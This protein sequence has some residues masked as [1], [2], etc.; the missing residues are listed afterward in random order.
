MKKT[1]KNIEIG[2]K[3]LEQEAV[4]PLSE[5][6]VVDYLSALFENDIKAIISN[7]TNKSLV[8]TLGK[9][10][11]GLN[12]IKEFMCELIKHFSK[13]S[14]VLVLDKMTIESE[15]VYV[16]WHARSTSTSIAMASDTFFIKDEK[17]RKHTFIYQ[18][19]KMY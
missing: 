3:T 17:I 19:N 18:L 5:R 6:I 15:I 11:K 12:E 8:I 10:Y 16:V 7:Y 2:D 13:R 4:I 1:P 14:T 9:T